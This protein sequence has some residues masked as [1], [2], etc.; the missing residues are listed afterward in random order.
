MSTAPGLY[1][2]LWRR[3]AAYVVD[4]FVLLVPGAVVNFVLRENAAVVFLLQVLMWWL[5]KALMESSAS[6][7]TL[8]KKA[9]GI[10]VTDMAGGR[11]SFGRASARYFGMFVSGIIL[12]IGFL[13]AGLTARKQA[14]HDLMA[15]CLVVR[16]ASTPEETRLGGGTMPLTGGVWAV[17]V[18]LLFLPVIGILAAIA[19]PAYSDYVVRSRI[20]AAII[21]AGPAQESPGPS[22]YVRRVNGSK[23]SGSIEIVLEPARIGPSVI[24]EGAAI[25]YVSTG[26]S[27]T[28]SAQGVP[29]RYL[30]PACRE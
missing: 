21:A 26:G 18:L 7:A 24:R 15:G 10:K 29:N 9:L 28:C 3:A 8:G 25:R 19:I 27:W 1:A 17:I 14:L 2:G 4:S 22:E 13:I 23:A 12:G 16:A 30:P 20:Q 11:I 5:Y 6:Q